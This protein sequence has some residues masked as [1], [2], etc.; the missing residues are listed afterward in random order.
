MLFL[1]TFY[2]FLP[3]FTANMAP[4]VTAKLNLP[5]GNPINER[6]L[7]KNKTYRG[8]YSGVIASY[9]TVLVQKNLNFESLNLINYQ[10]VNVIKLSFLLGFGALFMDSVKSYFKRRK[11]IK[12]GE[13]WVPFDQ[14]DLM[15]GAVLF[16][17]FAYELPMLET[18]IVF[19]T[20]PI[21]HALVNY[22]SYKLGMKDVWW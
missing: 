12:S 9:L 22:L 19:I 20:T 7:G 11:G 10:E 6:A 17:M 8:F 5:F 14:M 15:T 4:V 21:L 2:F 13:K 18:F 3:A 16:T 1:Q